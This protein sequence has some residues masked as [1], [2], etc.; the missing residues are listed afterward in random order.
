MKHQFLISLVL[1]ALFP[2]PVLAQTESDIGAET[3]ATQR[4]D[5]EV[6]I[7]KNIEVPKSREFI[8]PISSPGKGERIF[9]LSSPASV[10]A[11][12]ESG[13]E[14]LADDSL[15]L[16]EVVSR[17]VESP[18]YELLLHVAWR[19]PGAELEQAMPVWVRGGRIY[20]PEFTSIDNRIEVMEKV[21]K[22]DSEEPAL[23]KTYEFDEQTLEALELQVLEQKETKPHRGL[24]ELEGKITITLSRYLHAYTDLV[25]RRPRVSADSLPNNSAQEGYLG[26]YAADTRILNNHVLREHRRM[27]SKN[28][29][30]LDNPEYALL[31]LITPA[32]APQDS[33]AAAGTNQ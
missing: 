30:Y 13:Y 23:E 31:I 12:R 21:P 19:Q 27:R 18:R 14:L 17:L 3:E 32:A 1:C 7:F 10:A 8:L 26:A 20:G 15:R 4:Y 28:L 25:L 5:V 9:D 22:I 24:Y 2:G 6:V 29:H 16:V 33:G 11:A